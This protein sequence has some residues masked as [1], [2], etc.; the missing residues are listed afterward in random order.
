MKKIAIICAALCLA[1]CASN[2]EKTCTGVIED[3]SMNTVTV[4]VEGAEPVTFCTIDAD[5]SEANG[6]L[7]GSSITV[8]YKGELKDGTPALKVTVDTT[9]HSAKAE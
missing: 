8:T 4:S 5:K 2:D 9:A 1:A 6:L 7:L 3:A